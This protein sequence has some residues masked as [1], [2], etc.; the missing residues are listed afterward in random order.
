[1]PDDPTIC[2]VIPTSEPAPGLWNMAVDEVLL[3]AAVRRG[4]C[5][6]RWYR[7]SEPTISLGYFQKP[8][9]LDAAGDLAS[10][11]R[12]KRLSG[13]GAILHQHEWT[14]CCALPPGH[15]WV[16]S[17]YELYA[18]VHERII[19][20]LAK[21][22]MTAALRGESSPAGEAS[23]LCFGRGDPNDVVLEGHKILGSA[24]RRRRG[25]VLQHGSLLMRHSEYAPQ[26]P[27]LLDLTATAS[28][29]PS[30]IADLTRT[31]ASLLAD[32]T[33][34]APLSDNDLKLAD[35]L[36]NKASAANGPQ[37]AWTH[38]V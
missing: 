36:C 34:A 5:S 29:Q 12:V 32:E 22:G 8:D 7:W 37:A 25:A 23:F 20:V 14:Y 19:G 24:Q 6:L 18:A 27:G 16:R 31:I 3:E 13:G 35:T 2:R 26:F 1:M 10:L 11:P 30:F 9:E 21:Y 33:M 15:S 4:E 38:F 17:P 28:L